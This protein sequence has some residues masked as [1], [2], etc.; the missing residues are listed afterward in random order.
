MSDDDLKHALAELALAHRDQLGGLLP[1]LHAVQKQYG[2]IP[3]ICAVT[4]API[5]RLSTAEVD[6]VISFYHQFKRQPQGKHRVQICRAEACQ[7]N[8]CRSLEQFSKDYLQ[9]DFGESSTD[10]L[11]SL[12]SVYCLGLCSH[13]PAVRVDDELFVQ[14][15][16]DKMKTIIRELSS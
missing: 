5:F 10:G 4:V 7:A 13:G 2:F 1:L 3:E 14:V 15:D 11:I 6:G 12:D 9:L 16:Q 8:G